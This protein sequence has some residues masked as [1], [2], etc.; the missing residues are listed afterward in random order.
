MFHSVFGRIYL[1]D[2]FQAGNS[3]DY[4][5]Y[6]VELQYKVNYEINLRFSKI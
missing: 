1:W 6:Q 4:L 3:S 2:N 5:C